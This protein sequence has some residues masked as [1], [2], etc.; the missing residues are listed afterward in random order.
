MGRCSAGPPAWQQKH[1][2]TAGP[3]RLWGAAVTNL[4]QEYVNSSS[5]VPC[6]PRCMRWILSPYLQAGGGVSDSS[7]HRDVE[8][9]HL[10]AGWGVRRQHAS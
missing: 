3:S 5:K 8:P 2:L 6:S 4:G 7:M 10:Q 1:V 9:P